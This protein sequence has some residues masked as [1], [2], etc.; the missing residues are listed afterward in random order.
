MRTGVVAGFLP[1]TSGFR[2]PNRWPAGPAFE[3]RARYLRIGIGEVAEGLCGG[4]CFAAADRFLRGEAPP[5]D[6]APPPAGTAL[7][8]EIAHRQLDSLELGVTP[9]RF[10]WAAARVRLGRWTAAAQVREWRSIRAGI[11]TGRPASLGLV[12]SAAVNPFSLTTNHQV[13]GYAYAAGPAL[14][15]IRIY[16]PNHPGR[17]DVAVTL[18]IGGV[19]T[20]SGGTSGEADEANEAEMVEMAGA[21]QRSPVSL[22]QTT[23][24]PLLAL[25]RLPYRPA[26]QR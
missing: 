21:A 4:M 24:E 20:G 22:G 9:L 17:D 5:P 11:E 25:L 1:S 23:G 16:D 14:A 3:L 13:L 2:F 12:R 8:E 18:R 15:T 19:A 26:P 6:A 7:F 10:W